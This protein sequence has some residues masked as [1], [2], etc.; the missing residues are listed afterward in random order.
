MP[1]VLYLLTGCIEIYR[2]LKNVW[3]SKMVLEDDDHRHVEKY[4]F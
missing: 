2:I 4:I 1:L 3:F